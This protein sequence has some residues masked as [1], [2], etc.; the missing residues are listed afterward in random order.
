MAVASISGV[1]GKCEARWPKLPPCDVVSMKVLGGYA[2]Q[3]IARIAHCLA[4]GGASA[5]A[6]LM[7]A[8]RIRTHLN[9]LPGKIVAVGHDVVLCVRGMMPV[10]VTRLVAGLALCAGLCRSR[11]RRQ[12]DDF[13]AI[14]R[15]I[16]IFV[17]SG[18][19][20]RKRKW[21][22]KAQSQAKAGECLLVHPREFVFVCWFHFVEPPFWSMVKVAVRR[23]CPFRAKF[24][25][26]EGCRASPRPRHRSH[27]I[28]RKV[29]I[30]FCKNFG[31]REMTGGLRHYMEN[32]RWRSR[33]RWGG[34][35]VSLDR[36]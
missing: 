2:D 5:E 21:N 22:R 18:C 34:A 7:M 3:T 29:P 30:N 31:E 27:L 26:Q 32:L 20:E 24:R 14:A 9:R 1:A 16:L 36:L 17:T 28:L 19:E 11:K 6:M 12:R 33:R 25:R 35:K 4:T 10:L 15:F 13:V 23:E 8:L